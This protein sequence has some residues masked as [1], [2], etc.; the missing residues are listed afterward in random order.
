[1]FIARQKLSN[2]PKSLKSKKSLQKSTNRASERASEWYSPHRIYNSLLRMRTI[3]EL[4]RGFSS[5]ISV[6][7][8]TSFA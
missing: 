6:D 1:M 4:K 2:A 5:K 8:E 7:L 3:H